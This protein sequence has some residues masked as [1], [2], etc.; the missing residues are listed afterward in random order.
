MSDNGRYQVLRETR[1]LLALFSTSQQTFDPKQL[2]VTPMASSVRS[3]FVTTSDLSKL[4]VTQCD[5]SSL[6]AGL[7][8]RLRMLRAVVE[9]LP[10]HFTPYKTASQYRLTYYIEKLSC[11]HER[12]Y[13]P[14]A[15]PMAKRRRCAECSA[16]SSLPP[17]KSPQASTECEEAA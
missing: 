7:A 15:G 2:Q 3:E 12:L 8:P 4:T 6:F 17:K 16:V 1:P 11:G 10:Q 13:F 5:T 9:R 14:Q